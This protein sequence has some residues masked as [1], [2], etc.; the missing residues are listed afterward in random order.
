M[1]QNKNH[2]FELPSRGRPTPHFMHQY[3]YPGVE[4]TWEKATSSRVFDPIFGVRAIAIHATAGSSTYGA[5]SVMKG[6]K[7][8]WHWL[9]PDEDEKAHG[10]FAWACA[11]ESRAAWH[12]RNAVSHPLIND[13][14]NKINHWSLGI[15]IVNSQTTA[16][17][18]SEWQLNMTAKLVRYAWGKYPNLKY[19][20][21]HA[22]MDPHRRSDPGLNF[23]WQ[24]FKSRVISGPPETETSFVNSG[25]EDV[26]PIDKL[27]AVQSH[28]VCGDD[29]RTEISDIPE[30]AFT[31]KSK[32]IDWKMAVR[33]AEASKIVYEE[34]SV[35]IN[36]A[37]NNLGTQ[38]VEFIDRKKTQLFIAENEEE[39]YIVFRGTKGLG[40]WIANMKIYQSRKP[41]GRVHRGFLN[42]FSVVQSEVFAALT[43][44]RFF[45]RKVYIAGHSLGGALAVIGA[46]QANFE[47]GETPIHGIYTFGM[48][49][50]CNRKCAR[51]IHSVFNS[52]LLRF[53]N[54]E[55]LVTKIPPLSRH[56]GRLIHFDESGKI[57]PNKPPKESGMKSG[58]TD[59]GLTKEEFEALQ[60]GLKLKKNRD[61]EGEMIGVNDHD[62]GRYIRN[63]K[64]YRDSS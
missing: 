10:K 60:K 21:S 52:R 5:M 50:T 20:L 56:V 53:V 62:M 8:S 35:V 45:D 4:K 14:Q 13:G 36:W 63:L 3:W 32:E 47:I 25:Y 38:Q 49:K 57:K 16:D 17:E 54:N 23:D 46:A 18:F 31:T 6:G 51:Y 42:A 55:D 26:T 2:F 44:A 19:V 58:P 41:Y 39:T 59:D 61:A 37:K 29:P 40:D 30:T 15:E 34:K 28:S 27:E 11:P 33:L 64:R 9:V 24:K 43:R 12:I 7:A 1:P 22:M 48:P